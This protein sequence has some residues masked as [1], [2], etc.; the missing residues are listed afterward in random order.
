MYIYISYARSRFADGGRIHPGGRQAHLRLG[1]EVEDRGVKP[2]SLDP[3]I[4]CWI[5]AVFSQYLAMLLDQPSGSRSSTTIFFSMVTSNW[6]N[7]DF[8]Q[9]AILRAYFSRAGLQSSTFLLID[10]D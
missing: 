10:H 5:A 2:G 7:D 4:Q 6:S 1:C 9:M 8:P 3:V